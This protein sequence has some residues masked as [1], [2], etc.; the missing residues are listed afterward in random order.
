MGSQ[1]LFQ[2]SVGLV[3]SSDKHVLVRYSFKDALR[4]R[5]AG[6]FINGE[7]VT[8]GQGRQELLEAL[9][10]NSEMRLPASE[11]SRNFFNH[12]LSKMAENAFQS[13]S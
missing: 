5:F 6:T 1:D 8:D 4:S 3:F 13:I 11:G 7:N 10:E 9:G 2:Y 12:T